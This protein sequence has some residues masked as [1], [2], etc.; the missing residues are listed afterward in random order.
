MLKIPLK[1]TSFVEELY[2]FLTVVLQDTPNW[3]VIISNMLSCFVIPTLFILSY[4]KTEWKGI[5]IN[6][7]F[8]NIPSPG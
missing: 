7:V 4:V 8:I 6:E 1:S 3:P 2:C 5:M